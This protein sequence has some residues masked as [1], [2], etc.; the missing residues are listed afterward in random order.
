MRCE[1]SERKDPAVAK[2][3]RQLDLTNA[4]IHESLAEEALALHVGA[5]EE[6]DLPLKGV[7]GGH[8][9]SEVEVD[10]VGHHVDSCRL[11][12]C[13]CC[14]FRSCRGDGVGAK[15]GRHARIV[16]ERNAESTAGVRVQTVH[17]A[18]FSLRRFLLQQAAKLPP[19]A[20]IGIKHG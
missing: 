18:V 5:I 19:Q 2:N 1:S 4:V 15:V 8:D 14:C 6:G 17:T 13:C 12:C 7:G 20:E 10:V 11:L 3:R 16:F 9:E